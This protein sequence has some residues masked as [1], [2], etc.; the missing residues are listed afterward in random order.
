MPSCCARSALSGSALGSPAS[1][2]CWCCRRLAGPCGRFAS[3][4]FAASGKPPRDRALRAGSRPGKPP[5]AR[6]NPHGKRDGC[7]LAP[8][9]SFH[10]LVKHK[11]AHLHRSQSDSESVSSRS[12]RKQMPK[13]LW[14]HFVVSFNTTRNTEPQ[15]QRGR[16]GFHLYRWTC[17]L[18]GPSTTTHRNRTTPSVVETLTGPQHSAFAG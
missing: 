11:R 16:R 13:S 17:D 15:T 14:T 7:A 6:G 4:F 5:R 3:G 8:F 12:P 10:K 18:R 9:L 1:P 2:P